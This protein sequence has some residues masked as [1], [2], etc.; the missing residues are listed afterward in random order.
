MPQCDYRDAHDRATD[1]PTGNR[2]TAEATH[3][4]DWEDGRFSFGCSNHLEID[5][6]ATVKPRHIV[7]LDKI[8]LVMT[9]D[10]DGQSEAGVL[11]PSGTVVVY[12]C[13]VMRAVRVRTADG[14]EHIVN[15]NIFPQLRDA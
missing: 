3:R 11:L 4:I 1:R 6:S 2:C 14:V 8:N 12:V 10:R 9:S 7:A 5:E 13:H 15:G